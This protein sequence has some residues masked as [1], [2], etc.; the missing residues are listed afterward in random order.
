MWCG[1]M[2]GIEAI[3]SL[4]FEKRE[5]RREFL[6]TLCLVINHVSGQLNTTLFLGRFRRFS[7]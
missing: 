4:S 2:S 7:V 5:S 3:G 1:E 6:L